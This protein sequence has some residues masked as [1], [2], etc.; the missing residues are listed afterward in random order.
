MLVRGGLVLDA[1]CVDG[2][3]RAVD[4]HIEG[5]RIAAVLPRGT[6]V[7]S[8]V[9]VLDATDR[10]ITPGFFNAHYHSHDV[11]L[12]GW[13]EPGP[14]ELWVL[15]ALPRNYAP[16]SPEEI[17]IRTLLGAVECLRSGITTVQ[18]MVTL[19][20]LERERVQAVIDAYEE[21][22]I[23]VVLAL[24]TAD[25]PPLETSPY[26]RENLP[27]SLL[28]LLRGHALD[29]SRVPDPLE[30]IEAAATGG[31]RHR[32]QVH[33]AIAPSSPER[34]SQALLERL[35]VLAKRLALPVYTHIYIS[36]AEALHARRTFGAHGGSLVRLLDS[37]G[38]LDANL[39]LAH[40]VWLDDAE[41]DRLGAAGVNVVLNTVSNLKNKNGIAPLR[42]LL[43]AGVNV[44]LGCDNCSCTDAQNIF[45]AMKFASLL[46]AV[47]D[48]RLG[49]PTAIDMLRAAT[50]GGA[51]TARLDAR[52]GRIAPR[53]EADLVFFDLRD[54]TFV[55]FN[56]AARQLV[57]GEA[58]RAVRSVMVAGRMILDDGRIRTIDESRLRDLVN[59]AME[60]FRPEAEAVV[61]N[62]RRLAPY[63]LRA[64]EQVWENDLGF[65]RY[66]GRW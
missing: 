18:D 40:G 45:Q 5:R 23:R 56:N 28:P 2:A 20:P 66:V 36:K 10:L 47:S 9:A 25:V 55:P 7:A 63:L 29:A 65:G 4:L 30:V 33:W 50:V 35:A 59:E 6:P 8:D 41:V 15:N 21:V 58:G 44:A 19:W 17:R 14:L 39:S 43:Q 42:R 34:C 31:L 13:F 46:A 27:E 48:P 32:D 57:Y 49:P 1:D 26:W 11:L 52:L 12:K 60:R 53:M 54:P 3:P 24:Q 22:G 38:M 16:R 37:L 61:A 62:T 51:R 64:D